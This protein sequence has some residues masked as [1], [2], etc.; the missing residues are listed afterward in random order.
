MFFRNYSR[1]W[2]VDISLIKSLSLLDKVKDIFLP[3]QSEKIRKHL[4]DA[5]LVKIEIL[6]NYEL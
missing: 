3:G 6:P 4:L 2:Y 5:F 1:V